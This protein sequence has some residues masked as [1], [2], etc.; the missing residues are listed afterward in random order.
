MIYL[1]VI[2]SAA[3]LL[4]GASSADGQKDWASWRKNEISMLLSRISHHCFNQ[5]TIL[6]MN[7]LHSRLFVLVEVKAEHIS[8]FEMI[9]IKI[10][11]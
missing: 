11:Q 3:L 1:F 5:C 9:V 2:G 8:S 10:S 7:F 6:K 4:R